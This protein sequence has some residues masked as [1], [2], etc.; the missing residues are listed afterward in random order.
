MA[1]YL[2]EHRSWIIREEQVIFSALPWLSVSRQ[3]IE[4]PDGRQIDDYYQVRSPSYVEVVPVDKQGQVLLFW[5][6]RHGARRSTLGFAGGFIEP[7]ESPVTAARRELQEE[8]ALQSN[9]WADLGARV[10]DGNRGEAKVHVFIAWNCVDAQAIPSD[11]LESG[12][13][14]WVGVSELREYLEAGKFLTL[15]AFA[16]AL[17]VLPFLERRLEQRN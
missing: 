1:T 3:K 16:A 10:I 12:D 7:G 6:Y 14:F 13:A 8:C 11:D 2:K 9:E 15:G 17:Q 5:R 4:L